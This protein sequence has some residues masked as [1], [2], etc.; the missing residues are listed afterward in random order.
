[1]Y[2]KNKA[3]EIILLC[4]TIINTVRAYEE[5]GYK[6]HFDYDRAAKLLSE[7]TAHIIDTARCPRPDNLP[8]DMPWSERL[9]DG[10]E[11]D[12]YTYDG[13]MSVPDFEKAST[14]HHRSQQKTRHDM[15]R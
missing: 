9:Y 10:T 3:D 2:N 8:S 6:V 5:Q 13:S 1:M 12:P 7:T 4:T 11:F 14:T 15:E